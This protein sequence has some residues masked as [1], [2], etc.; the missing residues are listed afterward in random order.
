MDELKKFG[1][2]Q[3]GVLSSRSVMLPELCT[4]LAVA[5]PR[6]DAVCLENLV[7]HEDALHK[8]SAVNRSKTFTYLR[9]LYGLNSELVVFREFSRLYKLFPK[10]VVALAATLAFAR[11]PLLR[12]CADFVMS[13]P[14]GKA[15]GRE[16]FEHWVREHAHGRYSQSMFISFSHNLYASFYQLG[17]LGAAAGKQRLRQRRDIRPA[18]VAYAAFLDWLTG[19]NGLTLLGGNYSITLELNQEEHLRL[20]KACG[21]LGLMRVALAGGVLQLDFSDWLHGT[22]SRPDPNLTRRDQFTLTP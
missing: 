4:L 10:E 13:S 15:L 14:V 6:A 3:G 1:F 22:E 18:A 5:P 7:I 12:A 19:L 2:S 21:Q 16:D 9:R 20:L 8:T 17:Y 11:E